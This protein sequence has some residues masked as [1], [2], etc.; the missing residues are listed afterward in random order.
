MNFYEKALFVK[1]DVAA[2]LCGGNANCSALR[3]MLL[4]A[5]SVSSLF[6]DSV[7]RM[8]SVLIRAKGAAIFRAVFLESRPSSFAQSPYA[9]SEALSRATGMAILHFGAPRRRVVVSSP[10]L[11][12]SVLHRLSV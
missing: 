9:R 3:A 1:T 2:A 11:G 5:L 7:H 10:P 6:S 8:R 12:L 4:S